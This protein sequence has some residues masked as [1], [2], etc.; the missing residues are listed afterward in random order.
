MTSPPRHCPRLSPRA[1]SSSL[2]RDS[3]MRRFRFTIG[4]LIGFVVICGVAFG[5]AQGIERLVGAGDFHPDASGPAHVGA[6]RLSHRTGE[7]R[8]FL[9][10]IRAVRLRLPWAFVDPAR[11]E[12]V[13]DVTG[14]RVPLFQIAGA[15]SAKFCRHTH[16]AGPMSFSRSSR[17]L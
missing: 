8:G 15:S 10:R 9:A 11:R 2:V 7:R 13:G 1:L 5:A 3:I 16:R 12:Q 6:A 17:T 14:I 4:S